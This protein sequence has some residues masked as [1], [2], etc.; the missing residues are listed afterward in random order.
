MSRH[1]ELRNDGYGF[2]LWG[3]WELD[4]MTNSVRRFWRHDTSVNTSS[5]CG[6]HLTE[7]DLDPSNVFWLQWSQVRSHKA[8]IQSSS[9]IVRMTLYIDLS[10]ILISAL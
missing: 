8:T 1:L 7:R 3:P 9:D 2:D 5:R 4:M 6:K 10:G